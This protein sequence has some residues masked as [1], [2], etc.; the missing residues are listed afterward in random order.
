MPQP[1]E[2]CLSPPATPPHGNQC[3]W[4]GPGGF[5]SNKTATNINT[6][7]AVLKTPVYQPAYKDHILQVSRVILSMLLN[8][9]IKTI[10]V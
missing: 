3:G 7:N 8:M 10:C 9:H 6:V 1:R 2:S 4:Q 5:P